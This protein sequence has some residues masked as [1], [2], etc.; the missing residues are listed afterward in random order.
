M[1][2]SSELRDP[3][4]QVSG[5]AT[6][7]T[8][9]N[10]A[11]AMP[12]VLTPLG[13]SFWLPACELGLRAAFRDFG[14][15]APAQVRVPE[16]VDDR[17]S[18]VF[19]G[20][21]AAN[22]DVLRAMADLTPGSSG[23]QME[24]QL[25]GSVRE[26]VQRN[27]S[28]RRYPVVAV[29]APR[30]VA[31]LPKQLRAATATADAAWRSLV[32]AAGRD[33]PAVGLLAQAE[34]N[35]TASLRTHM[36]ATMLGQAA[37]DNL[38]KLAARAG[39]PGLELSLAGGYGP[40]EE[41]RLVAGL[42]AVRDGTQ[43]LEAFVH[44]FGFHG[45]DEGE[46]SSVSWREDAA[47]VRALVES[48][49][50]L[51]ESSRPEV[52]SRERMAAREQAE[53]DLLAALPRA[54]RGAARLIL[55]FGRT[56]LPMRE[57]SKAN[58]LK[59]IDSARAVSRAIGRELHRHGKLDAPDD[60]FYLTVEEV[61]GLPDNARELVTFRRER[62]TEYLTLQLPELWVGAPPGIST[63]PDLA[64]SD[65]VVRGIAAGQGQVTG[66][67]RIIADIGTDELLPGEVLVCATTDPSWAAAF[68]LACAVVID[69]GG[70]MSHGAIVAREF[71][72][73][74]VINTRTGT[75]ELATGDLVTVDGTAG[76]VT[77]L[78]RALSV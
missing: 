43:T 23:D 73:P 12:G 57:V 61:M 64:P 32:A 44:E 45:P 24:R 55:R 28:K 54:T 69:V 63:E 41:T 38:T 30:A 60:V 77:L 42:W 40:L 47:P 52:I 49:R 51:A 15:L 76:T 62:R 10:A 1:R 74:C 53:A 7:W 67:V 71:G 29:K 37:F 18:G 46:L 19:H 5:P 34:H 35:V 39:R 48:F 20:R 75:R 70:V 65:G 50:G 8:T 36:L 26:G 78:E 3:L 33:A 31:T 68:P 17:I 11:E 6:A 72:I 27:S 21:Y 9:V 2:S 58:F 13:I 22:L 16:S 56:Y 14:V 4:H 25:F 59:G 66:R